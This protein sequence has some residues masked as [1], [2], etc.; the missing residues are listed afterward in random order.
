M[1]QSRRWEASPPHPRF[2]SEG[3]HDRE[4]RRESSI[5]RLHGVRVVS[6]PVSTWVALRGGRI[7]M[8]IAIDISAPHRSRRSFIQH[9]VHL[10]GCFEDSLRDPA[11]VRTVR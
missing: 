10:T 2:D 1:W 4:L 11:I 8:I 9:W 5:A 7:A 6:H 3:T